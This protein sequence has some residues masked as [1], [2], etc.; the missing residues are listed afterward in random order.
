MPGSTSSED[1]RTPQNSLRHGSAASCFPT[2]Q[3]C[4]RRLGWAEASG[5]PGRFRNQRMG[6]E[7]DLRT[8][9]ELQPQR[10]VAVDSCKADEQS[11]LVPRAGGLSRES[12][13]LGLEE[14]FLNRDHGDLIHQ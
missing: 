10:L 2:I 5:T 3:P 11:L 12:K 4:A 1:H 7:V 13:V 14:T 9:A 6:L 8:L